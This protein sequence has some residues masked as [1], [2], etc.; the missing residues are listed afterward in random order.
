M[1]K[2]LSNFYGEKYQDAIHYVEFLF[3]ESSGELQGM[4]WH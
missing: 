1:L 2:S 4:V 3:I